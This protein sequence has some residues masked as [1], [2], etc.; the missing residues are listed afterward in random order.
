MTAPGASP[1]RSSSIWTDTTAETD[2]GRLESD[3]RV[4]TVIVGGGIAGLS[5]AFA[6]AT[7]GQSVAVV[8][9]DRIVEGVTG[10]TTAKLTA[11]H[12]LIYDYLLEHFGASEARQYADANQGAIDHVEEIVSSG[13][14]DC[15]FERTPAYT[16]TANEAETAQIR[17]E[18]EA[19]QRLGL[20]ASY[21]E[22]TPLPYDVAAAVRF[23]DQ[24]VFHPRKYLLSLA[25]RVTELGGRIFEGT[26]ALDLSDGDPCRVQTEHGDV[27]A[28]DVVVATLFPFFDH[29]MYFTRM[30][31]KRSYVL[32]V[33]LNEAP[34]EGIYYRAEDPYFSV[35][36]T[37]AG[38]QSM[39]LVGGQDHRTGEG[40][41]TQQQYEALESQA[42][43][44]LDVQSVEYRWSTQDYRSV[45]RVPFVGSHSPQ[46]DSVH[47]ATGF[48][49]WGMT[50]GVAAGTLLAD[51]VLGQSNPWSDV[52][53]PNR[54]NVRAAGSEALD[55]NVDAMEHMTSD[56]LGSEPDAD[57]VDLDR[58]EG[59]VVEAPDG[60]PIG[61]YRDGSGQHHGVSGACTHMD[62][63]VEFND[64]ER[65][66]DCPCHGSRF[67]LDGSV[68]TTPA[69]D[70]LERYSEA[71]LRERGVE[72]E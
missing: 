70:D 52:F 47:V 65:S 7:S 5:T 23:E 62:C 50:N 18:V 40:E 16:Y 21:V 24:A 56:V 33:R 26:R 45:D 37:P 25:E 46:T 51:R 3:C 31:P 34:P 39:A 4:D 53:A 44:R 11:Q 35:R 10:H 20:S 48:G 1:D 13:D 69:V 30:S 12:G 41:D 9:R 60:D 28:D 17:D 29:A 63:H 66:W 64:A 22:S 54:I 49:G 59:R 8:E 55:H 57:G 6:L 27:V 72:F 58:D 36:P 67:D 15:G 32:G 71:E 14:L 2:Y 43:D 42:R 68:L 61:V 38:E 19:A